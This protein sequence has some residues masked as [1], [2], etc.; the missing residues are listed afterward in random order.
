[1]KKLIGICVLAI[2]IFLCGILVPQGEAYAEDLAEEPIIVMSATDAGRELTVKVT[3]RR[4]SGISGMTLQLA[5]DSSVLELTNVER[6]DALKSLEYLTTK[7]DSEQGYAI[8]PFRINWSGDKNDTSTGT[9]LWMTFLIKDSTPDGDY[10]IALRA[11]EKVVTY[12]DG[13]SIKTK[14]V[15][16]NG[17][18]IRLNGD[19]IETFTYNEDN[20][21]PA[22]TKKSNVALIVSLSVAGGLAFVGGSTLVILSIMRRK[23][24][25]KGKKSKNKG[26]ETWTKLE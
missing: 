13:K 4:N 8:T 23:K 9:I 12:L 3:L 18:K 22:E 25:K 15:L 14:R 10:N 5:Y 16:I 7:V 24:G 11:P 21:K 1:M 6:G 2:M 19:T 17:V 20:S 26:N